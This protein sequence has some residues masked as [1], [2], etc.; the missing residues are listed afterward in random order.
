MEATEGDPVGERRGAALDSW[1]VLPGTRTVLMVQRS[2]LAARVSA[3]APTSPRTDRW[4]TTSKRLL[5]SCPGLRRVPQSSSSRCR[6]PAPCQGRDAESV[7]CVT[8]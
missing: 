7:K 4:S 6:L 3:A 1:P 8:R 2:E 5:G